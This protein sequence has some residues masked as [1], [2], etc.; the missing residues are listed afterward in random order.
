MIH[1]EITGECST[2]YF[3][4]C[5]CSTTKAI[6]THGLSVPIVHS[7]CWS[8]F[9]HA[10]CQISMRTS[11]D[12]TFPDLFVCFFCALKPSLILEN[13]TYWGWH[14]CYTSTHALHERL[15]CVTISFYYDFTMF[16]LA[17][18]RLQA[19]SKHIAVGWLN[20]SLTLRVLDNAIRLVH[21][22]RW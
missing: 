6:Q 7:V 10:K 9:Y 14:K 3:L 2:L 5:I 13:V 15:K 1:A 17:G 4:L 21:S 16:T 20:P 22:Q 8:V 11:S 12:V 19:V 18:G